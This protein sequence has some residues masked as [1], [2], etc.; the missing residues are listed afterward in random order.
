MKSGS[1]VAAAAVA[2]DTMGVVGGGSAVGGIASEAAACTNSLITGALELGVEASSGWCGGLDFL[3]TK[4]NRFY[5]IEIDSVFH[6]LR[7]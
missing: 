1:A 7:T 4:N 3:K 2:P 5:S 6:N